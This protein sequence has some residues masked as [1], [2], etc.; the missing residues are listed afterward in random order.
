MSDSRPD[1]V[2]DLFDQALDQPPPTRLDWLREQCEHDDRLFEEVLSLLRAHEQSGEFLDRPA[3]EQSPDLAGAF[4][5]AIGTTVGTYKILERI[6]SGGM[7]SVYLAER[8]DETF[9]RRVAIKLIRNND[10]MRRTATKE[11]ELLMVSPARAR[12]SRLVSVF[13]G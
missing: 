13:G 11:I 12:V 8:I 1:R 4:D 9:D 2:E 7:G 10:T 3:L 5:P 6:G